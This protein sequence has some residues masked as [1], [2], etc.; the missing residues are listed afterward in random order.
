[1]N[2]KATLIIGLQ[3]LIIIVLFWVLVFYG[4]D[5]YEA[6][7]HK[8]D[9]VIT[10]TSHVSSQNGTATITLSAESQQQSGISTSPL[11]SASHV[12][13]VSSFGMVT[14][15]ET[16]VEQ[17]TRY[18]AARSESNVVRASIDNSRQEYH[19]LLQLNRDNRNVSDRAVAAA[20]A[21]WRS[22]E[23]R[24]AAAE[25]AA[26]SIR[27]TIRQ[28]WGE[29]LASW[30]TQPSVNATLQRL[31]QS[32][33]VLIQV[34]LPFDSA[35]PRQGTSIA[36]EPTGAQGTTIP[37]SFVSVSPQT[38]ATIQG[39]TYFYQAAA[40]SLR[41]GMRVT[42]RLP[43]QGKATT[44][45]NVP[46]TAVVWYGN[47]AW[48][49]KKQAADRFIRQQISTDTEVGDSWF[50]ATGLKAGEE[51]VTNGAQLL[52]SEEFKYQIKNENED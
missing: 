29:T 20:E 21:A 45:V 14:G 19:R 4:K 36:I 23:A 52:L 41:A 6:A 38:D 50:N 44:G 2:R 24:L 15:I 17:R 51:V 13:A 40:G 48:I 1:M 12:A 7:T 32:Q 11:K 26:A 33:D 31:L 35:V 39:K 34:T 46:Q 3:T 42:A 5:E 27:D 47:K 43:A 9:D 10:G 8:D 49:Y 28:Q 30:A 25:T 16:L 22:D 18:L 37:A